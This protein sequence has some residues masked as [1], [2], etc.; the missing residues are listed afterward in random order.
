MLSEQG[1]LQVCVPTVTSAPGGSDSKRTVS[2]RG[3]GFKL[4]SHD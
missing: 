3:S 1:V 2:F 4:S